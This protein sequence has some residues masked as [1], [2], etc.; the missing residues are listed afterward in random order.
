MKKYLLFIP[1]L[2]LTVSL[3]GQT[4]PIKVVFDV[5]SEDVNTHDAVIRHINFM[6]DAYTDSEFEVVLYG[7]SLGMVMKDKSTVKEEVMKLGENDRVS[8]VVCEGA[9]KRHGIEHDQLL[10]GVRTV[11]DGIYEIVL[12]QQEGWGYIKESHK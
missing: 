3:W 11:P 5:T 7:K 4:I 1:M 6:A 8:F 9:M 12:K 10:K 2:L